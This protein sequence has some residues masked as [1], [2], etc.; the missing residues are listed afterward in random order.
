MFLCGQHIDLSLLYAEWPSFSQHNAT[1]QGRLWLKGGP[2][3]P[4]LLFYKDRFWIQMC[5]SIFCRSERWPTALARLVVVGWGWKRL[6]DD[7]WVL[8]RLVDVHWF[9]WWV[10]QENCCLLKIV[11]MSVWVSNYAGESILKCTIIVGM[12]QMQNCTII[13]LFICRI[14]NISGAS[15]QKVPEYNLSLIEIRSCIKGILF[16]WENC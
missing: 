14:Y 10:Q 3:T 13:K 2:A 4:S 8:V 9:R 1:V 11:F 7:C 16:H 5:S 15:V 6:G 12:Q